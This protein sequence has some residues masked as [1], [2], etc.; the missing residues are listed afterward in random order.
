VASQD[1]VVGL[2]DYAAFALRHAGI[3][4]AAAYRVVAGGR[5]VV[6]VSVSGVAGPLQQAD[7]VV[8]GLAAALR[9]LGDP[10][11]AVDV[12]PCT[13]LRLAVAAQ[14]E[15][16]PDRDWALVRPQLLA[17][18]DRDLGPAAR[19]LGQG[20]HQAEVVTSLQSV[21]GRS[22]GGANPASRTTSP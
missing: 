21:A 3:G 6:H 13:V 7:A 20:V 8:T 19:C 14:V 22:A 4:A 10:G 12:A 17:A 11:E 16:D 1:R 2:S 18:L 15:I 5:E 9:E